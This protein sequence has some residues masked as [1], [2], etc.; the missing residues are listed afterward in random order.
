MVDVKFRKSPEYLANYDFTDLITGNSY[1]TFYLGTARDSSATENKVLFSKTF[2]SSSVL[3]TT[4]VGNVISGDF[5]KKGDYDFDIGVMQNVILSGKAIAE[6][7]WL[8]SS[9]SGFDFYGYIIVKIRKYSGATETEIANGR[10]QTLFP[11]TPLYAREALFIDISS[12]VKVSKGDT[13]RI[14]VEVWANIVDTDAGT[15]EIIFYHD[16]AQRAT[17]GGLAEDLTIYLPFKTPI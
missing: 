8:A 11:N 2:D 13:L 6:I 17:A 4:S 15:N 5:V 14:T 9:G 16:P 3:T 7:T 12:D 10:T 1:V